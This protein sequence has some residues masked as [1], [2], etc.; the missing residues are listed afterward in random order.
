MPA[1]WGRIQ[2]PTVRAQSPHGP[3]LEAE[4]IPSGEGVGGGCC[5][6]PW[7]ATVWAGRFALLQAVGLG[8]YLDR[9]LLKGGRSGGSGPGLVGSARAWGGGI[10]RHLRD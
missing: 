6:C 10:N 8:L 4:E 9:C 5:D 3:C 1:A 2:V 7:Q